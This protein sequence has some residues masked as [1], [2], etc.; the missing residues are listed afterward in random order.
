MT[1]IAITR[2]RIQVRLSR[3]ERLAA[4]TRGIDL[5]LASI[6]DVQVEEQPRRALHGI[7]VGTSIPGSTKLGRWY[8]RGE[9][10]FVAFGRGER[11]LVITFTGER[12]S[13]LI[14]GCEDAVAV[15]ARLRRSRLS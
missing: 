2:D 4:A 5:P 1:Q 7:R 8:R 12:W 10:D 15:A 11:A 13:R 14:L 9:K 6:T 3:I